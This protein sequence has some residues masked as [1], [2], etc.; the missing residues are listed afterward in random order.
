MIIV[1]PGLKEESMGYSSLAN[2][3]GCLL[4]Y[5]AL[6]KGLRMLHNFF[7]FNNPLLFA[8]RI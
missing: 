4:K 7:C 8:Q 2:T 5:A 6:F 1:W 3:I